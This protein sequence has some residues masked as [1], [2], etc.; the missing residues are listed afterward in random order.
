M[1]PA[2][3]Y[4]LVIVS[5]LILVSGMQ[6]DGGA[7]ASRLGASPASARPAEFKAGE[8]LVRLQPGLSRNTVAG[9][10]ARYQS[11][12]IRELL[13]E[14]V[15]LWRVPSGQE[16]DIARRMSIDPLV[17]YAEPNYRFQASIPPAGLEQITAT[18]DDP[19]LSKQWAHTLM[20][21]KPA[22]DIST[23]SSSII[24]AI[25]DSG[26]DETHPDLAAKIVPGYDFVDDDTNP[27][28]E[29]GHG[30]HVAGIAAAIT[31]NTIGVAGMDWQARIM[32]VRILDYYGATN[33][34]D[35]ADGIVWAYTNGAKVLNLSLGGYEDVTAI[36]EAVDA[37]YAAGSLVVAAMGNDNLETPAYPAAYDNVL[38]VSATNKVDLVTYYSNYGDHC[39]VAAPGGEMSY[40]G[41]T[42]GIYST[43]PTYSTYMT[44]TLGYF[45]NYDYDRGTSM[46]APYVSGL[47]ALIWSV[48]PNLTPDQV[49]TIIENTAVDLGDPGW[50]PYYCHGRIDAYAA[51]MAASLIEFDQIYIPLTLKSP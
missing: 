5:L 39:D 2:K 34:A 20:Q 43:L 4:F 40:Y 10:H 14:G 17:V 45:V 22:W 46:A 35:V 13:L 51:L 23:G 12:L 7:A 30:T 38:A 28:D 9:L 36:K 21:S 15:Q 44:S 8:L 31:N 18:P 27:H 29:N 6:I 47:A 37:A 26:I 32:P 11:S 25:I 24:I 16:L 33:S 3:R 49:Q 41:D 1:K 19:S 42:N 50:D 48:Q